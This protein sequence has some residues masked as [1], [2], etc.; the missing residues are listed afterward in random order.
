MSNQ[1]S[2]LSEKRL[3]TFYRQKCINLLEKICKNLFRMF[4]DKDTTKEQLVER[5]S[6]LYNKIKEL[7][8]VAVNHSYHREMKVY[9]DNISHI[10]AHDFDLDAIRDQNMTALNRIQ[11]VKNQAKRGKY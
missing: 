1:S 7:P 3:A 4:R 6:E 5:F 2:Y 8:D 11:K 9:I 10:L